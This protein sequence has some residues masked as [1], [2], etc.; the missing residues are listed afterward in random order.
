MTSRNGIRGFLARGRLGAFTSLFLLL[1]GFLLVPKL[2]PEVSPF[3]L[4]SPLFFTLLMVA[5]IQASSEEPR[6]LRRAVVFALPALVLIWLSDAAS[7]TITTLGAIAAAVFLTFV[8]TRILGFILR[9]RIVDTEVILAALCIYLLVGLIWAEAYVAVAAN[10]PAA[11]TSLPTTGS[12]DLVYPVRRALTYFSY[13]TL[14]TVGYGDVSPVSGTAQS[15]AVLEAIIGQIY[16]VTMIARLV[17]LQVA[18]E[19]GHGTHGRADGP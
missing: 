15:L 8:T 11:F 9:A 10:D 18:H 2:I 5:A 12:S 3:R 6:D 1:L 16:L 7:P 19:R 14:T 17:S 4:L 13:V